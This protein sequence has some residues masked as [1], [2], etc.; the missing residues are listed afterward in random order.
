M[1]FSKNLKEVKKR[2]DGIETQK[3]AA[4]FIQRNVNEAVE[5]QDIGVLIII[6]LLILLIIW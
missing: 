3:D 2:L 1:G 4:E 5:E 6:I